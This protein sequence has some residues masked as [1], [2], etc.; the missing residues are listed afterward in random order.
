MRFSSWI[1]RHWI[2]LFGGFVGLYV[3]LPILAPVF[4]RL[5]WTGFGGMIYKLYA[6]QC[7]QLPQRS[8][9]LFGQKAM[10]S[11]NEIQ[12]AWQETANP[13]VLRQFLGNPQMG[14][15]IAWSDRM[16]SMYTSLWMCGLLWWPLRKR[17][18]VRLPWWGFA[19][20]LL[21]LAIDGLTHF[22]SD[23]AGLGQGFRDMNTWLSIL[24]GNTYPAEFYA[25]DALGS[26]N[27]WMRLLS[28]VLF[29]I[30]VVWYAFP[31]LDEV[32]SGMG[33]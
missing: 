5:G 26:F 4:M 14:W 25:G 1:T 21:P 18:T 2:V 9:F 19:I 11:L 7:H 29:G 33:E 8:F 28:G 17:I 12:S 22:V 30:G 10:Y 6:T 16:V 31:Y 24:T 32:F 13:F 3:G 15:K 23:L 27:S 20:F